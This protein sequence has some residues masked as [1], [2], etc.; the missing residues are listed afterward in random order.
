MPY[1]CEKRALWFTINRHCHRR[2]HK[3][4]KTNTWTRLCTCVDITFHTTQHTPYTIMQLIL[5]SSL[6]HVR[7]LNALKINHAIFFK[8]K[9]IW[10]NYNKNASMTW[11]ENMRTGSHVSKATIYRIPNDIFNNL[12]TFCPFGNWSL[13]STHI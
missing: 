5:I 11:T 1:A 6:T 9:K 10:S 12:R 4:W 3:N 8:H 7:Q 2:L 13:N